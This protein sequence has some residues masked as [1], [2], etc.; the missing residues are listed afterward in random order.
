MPR[1]FT[2]SLL[3]LLCVMLLMAIFPMGAFAAASSSPAPVITSV[4]PLSTQA[5]T[6]NLTI[7]G[8]GFDPGAIDQI[9]WAA[10][11]HFV[12]HGK[13][14]SRSATQL[15]VQEA[16]TGA[17]PGAYIAKVLNADRLLSTGVSFTV[18]AKVNPQI[19][20]PSP[21]S[22]PPGTIFTVNGTGF[23]PNSTAT[24]ILTG[25]NNISVSIGSSR[26]YSYSINSTGF[27]PGTYTN[28][29]STVPR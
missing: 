1:K 17:S 26:T 2:S 25:H 16:M 6:F 18:T 12:G 29:S 20:E 8:S 22:G 14:L 9:Y 21:A 19:A 7:N 24:S 10:D 27:T 28:R 23:T 15:V 13:V 5:G 4:S 11:G 3:I